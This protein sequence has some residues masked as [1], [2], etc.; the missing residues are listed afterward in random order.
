MYLSWLDFLSARDENDVILQFGRAR[1]S[2]TGSCTS[3]DSRNGLRLVH[4]Y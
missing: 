2:A 1:G 4:F 3:L